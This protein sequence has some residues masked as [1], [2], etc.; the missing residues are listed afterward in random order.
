[1]YFVVQLELGIL[2]LLHCKLS[3]VRGCTFT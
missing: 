1:M 3:L 2:L